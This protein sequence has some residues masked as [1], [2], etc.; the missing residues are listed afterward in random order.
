MR[1]AERQRN[2]HH[3]QKKGFPYRRYMAERKAL[4]L[5]LNVL[6]AVARKD[7]DVADQLEQG[8]QGCSYISQCRGVQYLGYPTFFIVGNVAFLYHELT[9]AVTSVKLDR[10]GDELEGNGTGEE[11]DT[12]TYQVHRLEQETSNQEKWCDTGCKVN[13]REH[14]VTSDQHRIVFGMLN[15]MAHLVT[16]N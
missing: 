2:I 1:S 5:C 3:K 10:Q 9:G 15:C 7:H 13:D 6:I 12:K 4:L 8:D 14:S 16:G 11:D